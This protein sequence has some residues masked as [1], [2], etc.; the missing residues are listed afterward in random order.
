MR[1]LERQNSELVYFSMILKKDESHEDGRMSQ[2]II[3]L[4]IHIYLK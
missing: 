3:R 4:F 1:L 2:T